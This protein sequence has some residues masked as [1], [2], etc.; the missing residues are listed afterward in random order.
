MAATGV[1]PLHLRRA[2]ICPPN[3]G[4]P[5]PEKPNEISMEIA[6]GVA[7]GVI[8]GVVGFIAG[9]SAGHTAGLAEGRTQGSGE[10][11]SRLKAAAAAIAR[12]VRPE[13]A[14]A[15]AAEAELH[16]ALEQGWAPRETERKAA[17]V[18]AI[19]RV[20]AFL[21]SSV[22]APLS[23]VTEHADA[24]EL[25]ERVGQALGALSDLDFFLEEPSGERE[26]CDLEALVKQVAREFSAD[27]SVGLRLQLSGSAI[28][29]SV[30][31]RTFMDG[32]YLIFHNAARFGGGGTVDVAVQAVD[33]RAVV[34]VRDRGEGFSEEAFR[35]AFDPF[36]S[37]SSE[38][39][40]LGLP[41]ARGLI[42]GMGG[43]IELS[44]VPDGG[45]QVEISFATT[46]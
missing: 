27:Q 13:G 23:G 42:E 18:E 38:G 1:L 5:R 36:Y 15:G 32:L 40:G 35:R 44:N 17:L 20:S 7:A 14:E 43:R 10:L 19:G 11:D 12:G 16:A 46:S 41:H 24:D 29:A 25:R 9:R 33:G 30:N 6:I 3:R 31:S 37:S 21:N 26:A 8:L 39:L 4:S 2:K 22:R 45:A 34:R 28:R